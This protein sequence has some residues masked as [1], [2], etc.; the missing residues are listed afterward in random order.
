MQ[1]NTEVFPENDICS[2]LMNFVSESL[3]SSTMTKR[4]KLVAT[5]VTRAKTEVKEE[6]ATVG[7]YL[8]I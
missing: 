1:G 5:P 4:R 6:K 3:Y 8:C 2:E 7:K